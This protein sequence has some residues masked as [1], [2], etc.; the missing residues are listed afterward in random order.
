MIIEIS[1][2][3]PEEH[4]AFAKSQWPVADMENYG[5]PGEWETPRYFLTAKY[6]NLV[7][8]IA[9][10]DLDD[11]VLEIRQII[12]DSAKRRQGI[13]RTLMDRIEKIAVEH[14]A[15][16][17]SLL[18]AKGLPAEKFYQSLQYIPEAEI[19]NHYVKRTYIVYV[20]YL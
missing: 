7:A 1:S 8:G 12:V 10:V 11:G 2:Y 20:K 4:T 9:V 16:K 19:P 3:Q 6:S 18:A 5:H 13:G 17:I 15:H 14:Q